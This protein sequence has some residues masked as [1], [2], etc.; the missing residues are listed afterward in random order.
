M[1]DMQ[2][3]Q[4]LL[5]AELGSARCDS[6]GS[7]HFRGLGTKHN[8][9]EQRMN[10]RP[11]SVCTRFFRKERVLFMDE[12]AGLGGRVVGTTEEE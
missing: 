1:T 12:N 4:P 2:N 5:H 3:L 6:G 8:K 11:I 9:E 10:G 7:L